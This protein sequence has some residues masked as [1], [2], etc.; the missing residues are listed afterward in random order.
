MRLFLFFLSF[1]SSIHA[2]HFHHVETIQHSKGLTELVDTNFIQ[3]LHQKKYRNLKIEHPTNNNTKISYLGS[4]LGYRYHAMYDICRINDNNF[5]ITFD[6]RF[7]HNSISLQKIGPETVQVNLT[8]NTSVPMSK[9]MV[10]KIIQMELSTF[11]T[12]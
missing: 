6:N 1:W 8:F 11:L 4:T 12:D 2:L 9:F 5:D 3:K 10:R 7:V